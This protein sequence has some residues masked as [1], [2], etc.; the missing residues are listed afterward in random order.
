MQVLS[1]LCLL[2]LHLA[3]CG[4]FALQYGFSR[5]LGSGSGPG[6]GSGS[7]SCGGRCFGARSRSSYNEAISSSSSRS[8][9]FT[10]FKSAKKATAKV[11]IAASM[12][13]GPSLVL[14]ASPPSAQAKDPLPTLEKIFTAVRKEIS[15]EGESITRLKKDIN[16]E[17]WEDILTY[18]REYDAGFRGGVLKAAWKQ[19]GS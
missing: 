15:P 6:S 16:N 11:V 1:L 18:T 3:V 9:T 17:D 13:F 14:I 4:A 5:D 19:L 10:A 7:G 8:T 12:L 2:S